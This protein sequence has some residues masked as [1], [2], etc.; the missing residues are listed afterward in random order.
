MA[1]DALEA[2]VGT[3]GFERP[4]DASRFARH[5]RPDPRS[6]VRIP[7]R[8]SQVEAHELFRLRVRYRWSGRRDS[9]PRPL[10]PHGRKAGF[11]DLRRRTVRR[12]SLADFR[13]RLIENPA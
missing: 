9:N 3:T 13:E 8:S 7:Q 12:G 10:E 6:R 1:R 4:P 11:G 5:P 2:V